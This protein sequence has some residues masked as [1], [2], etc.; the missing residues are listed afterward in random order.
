[1]AIYT[2]NYY[3]AGKNS[4]LHIL[5]WEDLQERLLREKQIAEKYDMCDIV[6]QK[7]NNNTSCICTRTQNGIQSYIL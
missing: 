5:T 1:M 3:V 6:Y 2:I 4:G 7:T